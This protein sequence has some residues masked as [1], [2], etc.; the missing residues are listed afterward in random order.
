[1][2]REESRGVLGGEDIE[3]AEMCVPFIISK[4][5]RVGIWRK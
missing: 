2:K 4:M 5:T 3:D 1:M